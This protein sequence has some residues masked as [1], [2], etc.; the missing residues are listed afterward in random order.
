[1]KVILKDVRLSFPDL[2]TP[3]PFQPGDDPRYNATF[4][5]PKNSPQIAVIEAA[6]LAAANEKWPGKGAGI[7]KAIRGNANKF[8]FQD[9]DLKDYDGYADMMYLSAHNKARPLVIDRD[10]SPLTEADGKPYAG[11]YVNATLEVFGYTNTGNGI[12]CGLKGVQFVRDGDAFGG[13]APASPD[14]FEDLG[15][16]EEGESLA[17]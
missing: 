8:C 2:Y 3:K 16:G 1:M 9:G 12:G 6:I 13:G 17:G 14:D 10:K 7:V 15:V 4:L 11:C 5:V